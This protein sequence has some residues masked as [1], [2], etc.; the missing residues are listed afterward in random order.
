MLLFDDMM[1]ES[2]ELELKPIVTRKQACEMIGGVFTP[3]T[4]RNMDCK[5]IGPAS[6]RKIG[7]KVCYE[8]ND[9]IHWLRNYK[10]NQQN[11]FRPK[12]NLY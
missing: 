2:L 8:K 10:P 12:H 5:N 7:K 6:K 1:F 3:E 4:L 11:N 9:F